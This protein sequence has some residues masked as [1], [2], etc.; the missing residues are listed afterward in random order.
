MRGLILGLLCVLLFGCS[1]DECDDGK[2]KTTPGGCG[3]NVAPGTKWGKCRDQGEACDGELQCYDGVCHPCGGPGELCCM[4]T[5]FW[6]CDSLDCDNGTGGVDYP[7]CPEGPAPNPA[8]PPLDPSCFGGGTEYSAFLVDGTC[9]RFEFKFHTAGSEHALD[10][11]EQ[12]KAWAESDPQVAQPVETGLNVPNESKSCSDVTD[13]FGTFT[14]Y[15]YSAAQEE[16]CQTQ[17]CFDCEWTPGS[18]PNAP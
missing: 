7:Y 18:C 15:H 2:N 6:V 17:Q 1:R 10:C 12:L 4:E 9:S 8:D 3:L 5:S 16:H 13:P 14:F 11:A